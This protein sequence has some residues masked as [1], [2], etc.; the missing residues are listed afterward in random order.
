MTTW[1]SNAQM[2]KT[3]QIVANRIMCCLDPLNFCLPWK[4]CFSGSN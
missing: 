3:E 1:I 2:T 4:T